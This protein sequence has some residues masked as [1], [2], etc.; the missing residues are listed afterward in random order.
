[1]ADK[2][3]DARKAQFSYYLQPYSIANDWFSGLAKEEKKSWSAIKKSFEK[4]WP[5]KKLIK[6]TEEEYED[7]ILGR[8]L[9]EEDL[10]KKEKMGGTDVYTHIT[11]ADKMATSVRGAGIEGS[12]N[13][14]RQV[15]KELP[16]IIREKVKTGHANWNTFLQVVQNIDVEYIK[17]SL[18]MKKKEQAALDRRFQML[19]TVT[20]SPTAPLQQQLSAA[21]ILQITIHPNSNQ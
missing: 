15:R 4:R 16:G 6:K 18:D 10:G 9:K 14:V 12:N 17:D 1:M 13:H 11:W 19:E 2:T 7:E 21:I 20:G 5:K 3:D 8:K